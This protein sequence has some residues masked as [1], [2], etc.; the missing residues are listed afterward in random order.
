MKKK[1]K[2]DKNKKEKNPN[3]ALAPLP[4]GST[5]D[6]T[7]V[8]SHTRLAK[9]VN[10]EKAVERRAERAVAMSTA[11][12]E[13]VDAVVDPKKNRTP[14]KIKKKK[15]RTQ[16]KAE[17]AVSPNQK[18]QKR[19]ATELQ[20]L[21]QVTDAEAEEVSNEVEHAEEEVVARVG[22]E[23]GGSQREP[24]GVKEAEGKSGQD[25]GAASSSLLKYWSD[26]LPQKW[27]D[28]LFS[29]ALALISGAIR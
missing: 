16:E 21:E 15:V 7:A 22:K 13:A 27:Q 20:A 5:A 6:N 17:E 28:P 14:T 18:R 3:A 12:T 9:K 19:K 4:P 1:A 24:D 26:I 2:F 29:H 8:P 11:A 10:K 25:P 23:A